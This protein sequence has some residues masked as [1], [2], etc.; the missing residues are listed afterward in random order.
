MKNVVDGEALV[1]SRQNVYFVELG[2]PQEHGFAIRVL[3]E[4]RRMLIRT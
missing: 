3:G 2:G 1:G 4:L